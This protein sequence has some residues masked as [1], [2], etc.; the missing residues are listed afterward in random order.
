MGV[1]EWLLFVRKWQGL[2][3]PLGFVCGGFS[4]LVAF[5]F[6]SNLV[7][8]LQDGDFPPL[9]FWLIFGGISLTLAAYSAACCWHRIR[10]SEIASDDD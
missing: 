5:G 2:R 3:R 8:A 7:E 9:V 6:F 1:A 4:A 10:R